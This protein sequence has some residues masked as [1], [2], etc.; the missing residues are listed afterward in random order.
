[1][2]TPRQTAQI[3][4]VLITLACFARGAEADEVTACMAIKV[5]KQRLACY[6]KA[7]KTLVEAQAKAEQERLKAALEQVVK[8]TNPNALSDAQK[9][10]AKQAIRQLN[11]LTAATEVGISYRDY[12]TR[13]VD[14]S[15]E[16]K[17]AITA[18]PSSELRSHLSSVLAD[19][20]RAREVWNLLIEA[21]YGEVFEEVVCPSLRTEYPDVSCRAT[22]RFSAGGRIAQVDDESKNRIL[23]GI[24]SAAKARLS[25]AEG[26]VATGRLNA[27]PSVPAPT[28]VAAPETEEERKRREE[29]EQHRKT[30]KDW[31]EKQR[32]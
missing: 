29:A 9:E 17:E 1:M 28:A 18:V 26:L 15:S 8:P 3:F 14:I 4:A 22:T 27:D 11:K 13:I 23:N 10:A 2:R 32:K 20:V 25:K 19:H 7:A 30:L 31:E 12:G 21:K 6:D 16:F 5:E 24:W